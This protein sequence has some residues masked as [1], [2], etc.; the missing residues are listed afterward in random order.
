M[1]KRSELLKSIAATVADYRKGEV[2]P[3]TPD[4]IEGWVQ[5]FPATIQDP[6]LKVLNDVFGK[7]Y[8][9]RDNFKAFLTGLASTD[10]VSPGH[11]PA[12]F[13][14]KANILSIQ[15][16][17]NSQKEILAT[18]DEVLQKTHRFR[19]ADTGSKDGDFIYLDDCIGT[20]TR[21]RTDVCKWLETEA[22]KQVKLHVITPVLYAGS[23]WIDAKIQ[24]TAAANGKTVSLQ[25]WRLD[26]FKMEN[27][28]AFRN[29]SDV[30]WPTAIPSD[31]DVQ[32]YAKYLQDLGHPVTLRIPGNPGASGIF[33]ND[34]ERIL[35]EQAFLIRGCQI[36][37]EC[38]NL[39]DRARPLGFHNLECLGF[40]SMF[41]TYRNCPNNCPLALWVQQ[42]EYQ[43]LLPR[44]TNTQTADENLLKEL[45]G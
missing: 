2:P 21:V 22:P 30:L 23:W 5:Q 8:I 45:L 36:R 37:Q 41:V 24:E 7:S 12:D 6:L 27:R 18:F 14:R 40:G 10:K 20:G 4:L 31:P 9:S 35:L 15:L 29:T 38:S 19:L 39:P 3:R 33:K 44:K 17:G 32:A 13:W 42:A 16:G 11:K 25:K 1:S 43:A 26:K 28:L 34:A